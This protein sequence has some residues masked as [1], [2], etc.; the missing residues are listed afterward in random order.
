MAESLR[1]RH[2][3]GPFFGYVDNK[4]LRAN[5]TALP[6]IRMSKTVGKRQSALS[7]EVT[8]GLS[9]GSFFLR[10]ILFLIPDVSAIFG[11]DSSEN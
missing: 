6:A 11:R 8:P 1:F 10:P 9:A 2:P 3:R 5:K 4:P 7:P